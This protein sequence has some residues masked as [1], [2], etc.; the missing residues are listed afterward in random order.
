MISFITDKNRNSEMKDIYKELLM[1]FFAVVSAIFIVCP[2]FAGDPVVRARMDSASI[3]MGEQTR[4]HLELVQDKNKMISMPVF[5]DTLVT[6]VEILNVS[7]PDTVLLGNDRIQINRDILVTSFDSGFYYIPP[8]RYILNNDTF[9]TQTLSLKVVPVEVDTTQAA[10]D[11]KGV[12]EPPFVLFDYIS[13]TLL[14]IIGI[15]I[16]LALIVAGYLY[17]RKKKRPEE[18]TVSPEDLLPPHERALKALAVLKEDKLWQNGQEKEYYTRL[19]EILREYIDD[20]FHINAMEMTSSQIL[21]VLRTNKETKAVDTQLKQI[22]EMADF[23]K[24]A[25]MRP[26]PDDNEATMRDAITFVEETKVV[27]EQPSTNEEKKENGV[28]VDEDKTSISGSDKK[29]EL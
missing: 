9:S 21:S 7:K 27:E 3:W 25:K 19:T 29:D 2:V 28:Q 26:L 17:Y 22:L 12:Q 15:I 1:K 5:N 6:G 11:I 24:F 13:D 18:K 14:T 4:I 16:L 10:I 23:V 20:R 8:F